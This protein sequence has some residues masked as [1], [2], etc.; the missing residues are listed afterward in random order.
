MLTPARALEENLDR[1]VDSVLRSLSA[2]GVTPT[3]AVATGE[4]PGTPAE[5]QVR[6]TIAD[7]CGHVALALKSLD[8]SARPVATYRAPAP[9]TPAPGG[10]V[11][12]LDIRR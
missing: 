9:P 1:V 4:A 7:L 3:T 10:T 11:R 6:E 5:S 2:G 12:S 8:P